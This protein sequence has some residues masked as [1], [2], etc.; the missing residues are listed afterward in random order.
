MSPARTRG[1]G[2]SVPPAGRASTAPAHV[3]DPFRP[4]KARA[5]AAPTPRPAGTF[6]AAGLPPRPGGGATQ[7]RAP[8][9]QRQHPYQG[10][11]SGA[12]SATQPADDGSGGLDRHP[13][14]R[15]GRRP[16]A[17]T[18]AALAL[19]GDAEEGASQATTGGPPSAAHGAGGG[20]DTRPRERGVPPRARRGEGERRPGLPWRGAVVSGWARAGGVAGS[21]GAGRGGRGRRGGKTMHEAPR[22]GGAGGAGRRPGRSG[23]SWDRSRWSLCTGMT[24]GGGGGEE[25]KRHTVPRERGRR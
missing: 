19:P 16:R 5:S 25:G 13:G 24:Q 15:S 18:S 10:T 11:G 8:A 6:P 21:A 23:R 9:P 1:P 14:I 17:G 22:E 3:L 7:G 4:C 20:A 2:R 12:R